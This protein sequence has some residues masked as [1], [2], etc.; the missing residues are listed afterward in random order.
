MSAAASSR[1]TLNTDLKQTYQFKKDYH[2]EELDGFET[3]AEPGEDLLDRERDACGVGF[4]ASIKGE[5]SNHILKQGLSA[6]ECNDHRGGCNYDGET[7]DG[8]GVMAE[9]P[10]TIFQ[11]W[12]DK[13]GLGTVDEATT[14]VG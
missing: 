8:S 12:A 13:E 2:K 6:L 3:Y 5:K 10:W 9:I 11:K 4:V 1:Q 7:G 14:C